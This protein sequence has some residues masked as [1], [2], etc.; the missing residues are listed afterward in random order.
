MNVFSIWPRLSENKRALEG[1]LLRSAAVIVRL[2][3]KI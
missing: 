2:L 1:A 3:T